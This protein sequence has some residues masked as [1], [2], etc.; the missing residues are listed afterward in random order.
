MFL[1]LAPQ[2]AN[3]PMWLWAEGPS[4]PPH[5]FF[6]KTFELSG[7]PK[8][9]SLSITCDDSY[10]L[11]V[12]GQPL[13][14]HASWYTMQDYDLAPHLKGG[15]NVI[16][17]DARNVE[18]FAGLL[19]Q[20]KAGSESLDTDATWRA[21]TTEALQWQSNGF[22]DSGWPGA[23]IEGPLGM[24][25][26]HIPAREGQMLN[27]MLT[28]G[29]CKPEKRR[30][31]DASSPDPAEGF[32]WPVNQT[33]VR[34][35]FE[36]LPVRPIS[37]KG[38]PETITGPCTIEADFGRELA[39]WVEVAVDAPTAPEIEIRVGEG[40]APQTD[41][42]TVMRREDGRFV[43]RI[44]PTGGFTGFRRAWI[45]FVNV[46]KPARVTNL[47]AIYRIFPANYVGSFRCSDPNLDRIWQIGAYT[48]R[49]NL[50]PQVLGAILRPERTDRFPWMGDDRVAHQALFSAF[51]GFELAKSDLEFFVKPGD[52]NVN[53]N[54]IPGYTMDWVVGLYDYWMMSGDRAEV[55]KYLPETLEIMRE[56]GG[57]MTPPGWPFTDWEPGLQEPSPETLLS[58]RY[59]YIQAANLAREM[60]NATGEKD[61]ADEFGRL[62]EAEVSV[63]REAGV[64]PGAHATALGI[65]SGQ[66]TSYS[67]RFPSVT[68]TPYF[69]YFVLEALSKSGDDARALDAVRQCWGGMLRQGA[70]S[71]WEAFDTNWAKIY[72]KGKTPPE[73]DKPGLTGPFISTAHPWSAGA[74]AWLTQHI[75]GVTPLEPGFRRFRV[76]PFSGDLKWAEGDLPT[77]HGPIHVRWTKKGGKLAIKVQAPPGTTA[78]TD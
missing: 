13:G 28:L 69:T 7:T 2:A 3:S 12:N 19:V 21:S 40:D 53:V 35:K 56:L 1:P 46:P 25:P 32:T 38:N 29:P 67:S 47:Q 17:V 24:E 44:L 20:G 72:P 31:R 63:I 70:T 54:G 10:V 68:A 51:G 57:V 30:R 9:A 77:P 33:G 27:D 11:Y 36:K 66:L 5:V 50:D 18:S 6:R 15:K 75:L 55:E 52:R 58:F 60:A 49:L 45:R 23:K 26:W 39:G 76:K 48:T 16:A 61:M 34:G 62:A 22:D 42:T 14:H 78:V 4:V 71:T 65:L 41:F 64:V 74:T 73:I 37:V 59:K 43:Y 8:S